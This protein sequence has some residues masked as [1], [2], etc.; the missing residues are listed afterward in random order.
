MLLSSL[1][2]MFDGNIVE[3]VHLL[4]VIRLKYHQSWNLLCRF[5]CLSLYD[6]LKSEIWGERSLILSNWQHVCLIFREN[7]GA[8][9]SLMADYSFSQHNISTL[10]LISNKYSFFKYIYLYFFGHKTS[11]TVT[12]LLP[13]SF[14]LLS[15][16]HKRH[17]KS[18][19]I[20]CFILSCTMLLIKGLSVR[21]GR[22]LCFPCR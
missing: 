14:F 12:R 13:D 5:Y 1:P 21:K 9:L 16:K 2:K 17:I 19:L 11:I 10:I 4:M 20:G 3:S 8:G 15:L 22:L 18:V 6:S 7:V